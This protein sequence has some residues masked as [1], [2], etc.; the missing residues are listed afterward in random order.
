MRNDCIM[1]LY[2]PPRQPQRHASSGFRR[3][4]ATI[5]AVAAG[6]LGGIDRH[7]GAPHQRVELIAEGIGRGDAEAR[8]RLH[9]RARHLH[10]RHLELV[11]DALRHAMR[12][13]GGGVRQQAAELLAADAEQ[14]IGRPDAGVDQVD[15][16]RQ[17]IVA[18]GMAEAVVERLEVVEVEE[19]QAERRALVGVAL[20]QPRAARHEGAP[21]ERAGQRIGLRL[22]AL[23]ELEALLGQRHQQHRQQDACGRTS[24]D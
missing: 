6:A 7:V 19:Q 21:V 17:H 11:A 5:D 10:H 23:V 4:V 16:A 18:A 14:E 13:L 20:Q 15:E 12:L 9:R 3:P 22:G 8:R 2:Q 24:P 1:W